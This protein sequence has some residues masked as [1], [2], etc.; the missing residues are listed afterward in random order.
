MALASE[1][2]RQ[3]MG[4]VF[5]PCGATPHRRSTIWLHPLLFSV[6]PPKGRGGSPSS[7]AGGG[8]EERAGEP[9]RG[10]P[11]KSCASVCPHC[12]TSSGRPAQNFD[13]GRV[14]H[15]DRVPPPTSRPSMS[16]PWAIG[17]QELSLFRYFRSNAVPKPSVRT[18]HL[19]MDTYTDPEPAGLE[20]SKTSQEGRVA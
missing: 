2:S 14:T 1:C 19:G 17:R 6:D 10:R 9:V 20:G 16:R 18:A 8:R 3:K 7:P 15:H 5:S 13:T 11:S 4:A 12:V